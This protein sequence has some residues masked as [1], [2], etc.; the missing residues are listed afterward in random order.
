MANPY[1]SEQ[2]SAQ[3][4]YPGA[5]SGSM[6]GNALTPKTRQPFLPTLNERLGELFK[7]SSS[8]SSDLANLIESLGLQQPGSSERDGAVSPTPTAP[9]DIAMSLLFSVGRELNVIRQRIDAIRAQLI[10]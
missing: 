8:S 4:P 3:V 1:A 5:Q 7:M 9:T 10:G 2:I 6:A